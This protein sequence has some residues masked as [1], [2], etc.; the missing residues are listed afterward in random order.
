MTFTPFEDTDIPDA[1]ALNKR[2]KELSDSL[3]AL[4]AFP[5]GSIVALGGGAVP[6]GWLLCD[7]APY[8]R[9]TY[10]ALFGVIDTTFGIGNGS[11]TFNVPDLRGRAVMGAG[12]GSGLTNRTLATKLGEETHQLTIPEMPAHT[13]PDGQTDNIVAGAG[14]SDVPALGNASGSAGS[15]TAHNNMQPSL[16]VNFIIKT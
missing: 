6:T 16:A 5:T 13:H 3:D 12:Q 10:A 7:G 9:A 4:A 15:D 1:K 11:T 14:G 8:S 2:F